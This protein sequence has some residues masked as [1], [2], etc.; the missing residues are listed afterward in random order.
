MTAPEDLPS[1]VPTETSSARAAEPLRVGLLSLQQPR[2]GQGGRTHL[3]E[4][5]LALRR[6]GHAVA[7]LETPA[8]SPSPMTAVALLGFQLRS[9]LR[10]RRADVLLL[11]FHPLALPA[12]TAC[13]LL[14][15]PV[16]VEVNGTHEDLV[17]IHPQLRPLL[18]V[19]RWLSRHVLR[20]ASELVAV[21]APLA[22]WIREF[23]GERADVVA[24]GAATERFRPE[25]AWSGQALPPRF[26]VFIGS[27]AP[28]QG[29][30]DLLTAIRHPAWPKGL[31]LVVAG[32]G[33][34]QE[35]VRR[36]ADEGE[37]RYLGRIRYEDVPGLLAAATVAVAPRGRGGWHASPLK[38]YEALASGTPV[39]ATAVTGQEEP[40]VRSGGGI[41]VPIGDPGLF[42]A[43]VAALANDPDRLAAAARGALSFARREGSW[44]RAAAELERSLYRA[45][46]DEAGPRDE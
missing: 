29:L 40:I 14:R 36:A 12:V 4:I 10:L 7:L 31:E 38:V 37:L 41:V 26:A 5:V 16:V 42:A 19:L 30:R 23:S 8:R 18:P 25:A 3:D 11:R 2:A 39:V 28:W 1:G 32:D 17:A 34:A 27:L 6:R 45:I 15:R 21:S 44:D 46:A 9:V 24:N 13:R 43:A 35:V 22:D 20:S 33:P